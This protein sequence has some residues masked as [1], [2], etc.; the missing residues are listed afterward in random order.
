MNLAAAK[1][2]R[3]TFWVIAFIALV[4]NLIGL[5]IFVMQM[6]LTPE[7]VAAMPAPQ[8]E[9]YA[10]TPAW[11]NVTFGIAVITGVL[12]A[13]CL[14][15]KRRWAVPLFLISALAIAVQLLG[16]YA[17]TPVWRVSGAAGL[18]L[19]V[20]LVVIAWYLWWYSRDAAAK[21]WIA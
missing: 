20:M 12:A 19:P 3:W 6:Q 14:M 11:I 8:R 2:R 17:L 4:W 1:P 21:G 13:I 9:V 15:L 10:A 7:M 18:A 16:A 5:S